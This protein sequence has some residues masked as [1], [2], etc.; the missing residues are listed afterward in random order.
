ME[1]DYYGTGGPQPAWVLDAFEERDQVGRATL[2]YVSKTT[3]YLGFEKGP[4]ILVSWAEIVFAFR[5]RRTRAINFFLGILTTVEELSAEFP[6]IIGVLYDPY[7]RQVGRLT[8]K[9]LGDLVEET[10]VQPEMYYLITL[11]QIA[12]A[13]KA[14]GDHQ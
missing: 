7:N 6:S 9:W 4:A 8:R 10:G 5:G 11:P 1:V 13:R 3:K 14:L 2:I 12:A